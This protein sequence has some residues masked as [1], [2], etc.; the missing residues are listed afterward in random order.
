MNA[1]TFAGRVGR[2]AILRK[3]GGGDSV[4]NFSLAVDRFKKDSGPLWLSVSLWGKSADNL[5]QYIKKG[6]Q[7]VVSG[8]VDL[9]SYDK[10][11]ETRTELV[12]NARQ[13][14]LM[15]GGEH[16]G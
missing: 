10:D 11:G 8:D 6:K 14:T 16:V 7:L 13:V 5:T 3:T 12:C 9:R 15:G 4:S 2:D 1:C